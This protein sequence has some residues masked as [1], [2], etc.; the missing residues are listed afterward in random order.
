MKKVNLAKVNLAINNWCKSCGICAAFCAAE[1]LVWESGE[2]PLFLPEK[3]TGC[4][5]CA[6]R[7]PDFAITV[8]VSKL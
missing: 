3:C 6:L 7:C 1:A 5:L 8:E 2:K 4:G